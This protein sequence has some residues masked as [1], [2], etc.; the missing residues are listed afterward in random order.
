MN[1]KK[2]SSLQIIVMWKLLI[3][4]REEI[5]ETQIITEM[6]SNGLPQVPNKKLEHKICQFCSVSL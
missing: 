6:V 4:F 5:H 2:M 3:D 1:S